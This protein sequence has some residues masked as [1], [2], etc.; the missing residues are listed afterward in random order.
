MNEQNYS[1]RRREKRWNL[2]VHLRVFDQSTDELLGHAVDIATKG[3]Q[4]ISERPLPAQK[5]FLL[6]LEILV[7]D[8]RWEKVPVKAL[9]V[10][11]RQSGSGL[12]NTGFHI[13]SLPA[14]SQQHIKRL[15]DTLES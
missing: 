8:G 9:S 4:L 6:W 11:S 10:W 1:D 5:N 13:F 14:E 7:D 2:R 12:Y 3:L 15:L